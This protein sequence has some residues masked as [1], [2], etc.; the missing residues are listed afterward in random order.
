MDQKSKISALG[1]SLVIAE[2]IR[3]DY[4]VFTQFSGK[5]PFDMAVHKEGKLYRVEVKSTSNRTKE[6]RGWK[7]QLR[8]S[9][10]NL[11]ETKI[12][13]FDPN[14]CDI[15]A[16]FIEP[17]NKIVILESSNITVRSELTILDKQLEE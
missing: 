13:K 14:S 7:V 2:F 11:T 3:R 8:K 12:N 9:R 15:L 1:E 4:D 17:V 6:D 5:E 10:S 16:V